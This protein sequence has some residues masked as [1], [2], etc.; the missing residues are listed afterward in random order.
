MTFNAICFLAGRPDA[1]FELL[2]K[3]CCCCSR[4][5]EKSLRRLE[6]AGLIRI[7]TDGIELLDQGVT[8]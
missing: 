7:L 5:I 6:N 3:I 1:S 2:A 8:Q 4:R